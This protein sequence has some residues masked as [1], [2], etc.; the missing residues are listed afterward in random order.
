MSKFLKIVPVILGLTLMTGCATAE[1][2]PIADEIPFLP[3]SNLPS[4][5]G[6]QPQEFSSD[7]NILLKA[8]KA[9]RVQEGPGDGIDYYLYWN[10]KTYNGAG[11]QSLES[12]TSNRERDR[13]S[14]AFYAPDIDVLTSGKTNIKFFLK[15]DS[16]GQNVLT[17]CNGILFEVA[18]EAIKVPTTMLNTCDVEEYGEQSRMYFTGSE[19]RSASENNEVIRLFSLLAQNSFTVRLVDQTGK[20]HVFVFDKDR[21]YPSPQAF[22]KT[23]FEAAKAVSIGLGY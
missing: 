21:P 1:P 10:D 5:I 7:S 15:F 14:L 12:K 2:A 20:E 6:T 4:E 22:F 11:E 18:G 3:S 16:H 8:Y 19:G 13:I 9:Y 17:L 23:A